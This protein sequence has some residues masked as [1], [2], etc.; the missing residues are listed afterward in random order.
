MWAPRRICAS[1]GFLLEKAVRRF[2][3]AVFVLAAACSAKPTDSAPGAK[4]A[5]ST[6]PPAPSNAPSASSAASAAAAKAERPTYN[7]LLITMDAV[8]ADMPWQGYPRD[9]APNLTKLAAESVV[10]ENAYSVSSYTAKSVGSLLTGRYPRTLYRD[11]AFFTK[12]GKA[13]VFFPELLRDH[14]VHTIGVQGHLYFDHEKNLSQGFDVWRQPAGL[15]F[16]ATTDNAITSPDITKIGTEVLGDPK[17]TSGR[18]FAWFHYG[19]PH[20]RYQPHPDGPKFGS[21]GRD[22][23]DGEIYFTDAWIAKLLAF[24]E[25]QPWWKDTVVIVSADHGEGFGEHGQYFHGFALWENLVRVPLFVKGPGMAPRHVALRRSHIDLAPTILELL[26]VPADP[27]FAGKSLVAELTGKEP[28]AVHEPILLDLPADT[29]NPPTRAMLLGDYKLIEDPG[30]KYRLFDVKDDPREER[31]LASDRD[32][33]DELADMKTRF[34]KAWAPFAYVAPW[35]GPKKLVGGAK[36][37]GPYGPAGWGDDPD[38]DAP[39]GHGKA[40]P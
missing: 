36:A 14:G 15:S 35:P 2:S 21:T 34:E 30:P 9:I 1:G 26:G 25:K 3:A 5:S 38:A 10:Y 24:C 18:F 33:G 16:D 11:E 20:D 7:V 37:D 12:Y 8:R 6:S 19:D 27:G 4:S 22:L 17:N 39:G 28:P 31:N 32:S 29:Y 40:M 13:N 23:Y